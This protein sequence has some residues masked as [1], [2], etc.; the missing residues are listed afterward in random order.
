M[1]SFAR[2]KWKDVSSSSASNLQQLLK[3]DQLL[4]SL[5][6][7][8]K[9]RVMLNCGL[10]RMVVDNVIQSKVYLPAIFWRHTICVCNSYCFEQRTYL[11]GIYKQYVA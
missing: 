7:N 4:P 9:S 5:R 6:V 3:M 10:W 11:Q 2:V 1:V 8:Q